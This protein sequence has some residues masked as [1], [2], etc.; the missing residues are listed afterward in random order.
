MEKITYVYQNSSK[1]GKE[2]RK[3]MKEKKY[4]EDKEKVCVCVRE[5]DIQTTRERERQTD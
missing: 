4:T 2:T 1:R 5:R 3:G